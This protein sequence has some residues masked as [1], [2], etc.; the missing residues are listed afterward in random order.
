MLQI[1]TRN[2]R[3]LTGALG[4][5]L[6]LG[7]GTAA[8]VVPQAGEAETAAPVAAE[9]P[10]VQPV[11]AQNGQVGAQAAPPTTTTPTAPP[12]TV[13]RRAPSTTVARTR[14]PR[15]G[16]APTAAAPAAPAAASG[17]TTAPRRNPSSAEVQA[18]IAQVRQ[19]L[20][21][22]QPTEAQARQ[23]GNDICDAF[24]RSQPY[25]QVKAGVQAAIAKVPF[26][27]VSSAD[28]DFAIRSAVGLF[29]PGYLPQLP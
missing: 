2:I 1:T 24:D 4:V 21:L 16:A 25:S 14:A 10:E 29:C 17:P 13:A 23:F 9:R 8:G 26:L 15:P 18:A 20:P 12:T 6:S 22:Y 19:R 5:T 11:A 3:L 28:I 27:T 7:V